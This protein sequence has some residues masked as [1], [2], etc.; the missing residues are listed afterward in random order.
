MININM[1]HTTFSR[2]SFWEAW[3]DLPRGTFLPPVVDLS[4]DDSGTSFLLLEEE[5]DDE[6]DLLLLSEDLPL[7]SASDLDIILEG[8]MWMSWR[9]GTRLETRQLL[10]GKEYQSKQMPDST[11]G[12]IRKHMIKG[13]PCWC[14]SRIIVVLHHLFNHFFLVLT[15][16]RN[17]KWKLNLHQVNKNSWRLLLLW[18]SFETW[19]IFSKKRIVSLLWLVDD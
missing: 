2:S 13:I 15:W 11:E 19:S 1:K 17:L 6:D 16:L 4:D 3:V 12:A 10:V 5:F 18:W 9:I 8:Y 14:W 7:S